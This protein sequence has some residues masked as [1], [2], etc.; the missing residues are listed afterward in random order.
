MHP[1]LLQAVLWILGPL[2]QFVVAVIIIHRRLLKEIPFFWGYTVFHVLLA[3]T[4]YAA[5]RVSYRAYF[6]VYWGA[7]IVDMVLTLLVIQEL[8]SHAFAPYESIRTLGR[9]LFRSAALIMIISSILLAA[10]SSG[11]GSSSP[12]V[13][14]FISLERSVHVLEIGV[15]F[16]L[17]LVCRIFGITW[18][19]FTFGIAIGM[20]LT[21]SGE[22][23]AA[24]LRAFLGPAGNQLYVWLEPVSYTVATG[25]WAYYA[26]SVDREAELSSATEFPTQLAEW[27]RAL[28]PFVSKS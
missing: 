2:L 11:S 28:E 25:I 13:D 26:L 5:S 17:F 15:L 16:V 23:I 21:L 19:R 10:S 4:S 12:L 7:E 6:D 8:F 18:Q 20:G 14:R 3:V 9:I 24:A 27:N 1:T 22:A